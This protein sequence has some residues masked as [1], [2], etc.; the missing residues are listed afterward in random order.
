MLKISTW[1][2]CLG[3]K[4]KK[5]YVKEK[6]LEEKIDICCI[7]ECDIDANYPVNALSFSGYN[8]EVETNTKKARCCTYIKNDI[9]YIRR[10]DLEGEDNNLHHQN[11][12]DQIMYIQW[13]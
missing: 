3:L 12:S 8:I 7:Q 4:S 10:R 2:I 9:I 1:N 11:L 13:R 6:I 5:N